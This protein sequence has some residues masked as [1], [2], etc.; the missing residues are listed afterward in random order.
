MKPNGRDHNTDPVLKRLVYS[1]HATL[2]LARHLQAQGPDTEGFQILDVHDDDKDDEGNRG[3]ISDVSVSHAEPDDIETAPA[4]ST[5]PAPPP[6]E[7][8]Q[9]VTAP[10]A[11][12]GNVENV[13]LTESQSQEGAE[14]T[15]TATTE[16]QQQEGATEAVTAEEEDLED[17]ETQA[18]I[19]GSLGVALP[20][21]RDEDDDSQPEQKFKC[22][23]PGCDKKFSEHHELKGTSS[24]HSASYPVISPMPQCTF[25]S[26]TIS[27]MDAHLKG[28]RGHIP[29]NVRGTGMCPFTASRDN[30]DCRA[31]VLLATRKRPSWS[32]PL[33]AK[34]S[35]QGPCHPSSFLPHCLPVSI[36]HRQRMR[37]WLEVR[38][39]HNAHETRMYVI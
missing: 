11:S 34:P 20:R 23:V 28:V 3:H 18:A 22:T 15:Q 16:G 12:G 35:H 33:L 24:Y 29:P 30:S 38:P 19:A 36:H 39:R 9:V 27:R 17:E 7:E 25:T 4:V 31:L 21:A 32:Q 6:T 26:T 8:Q 10:P 2:I 1:D 13:V 37:L 14:V 5:D